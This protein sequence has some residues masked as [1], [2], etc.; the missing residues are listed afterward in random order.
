[1]GTFVLPHLTSCLSVGSWPPK[2]PRS[3]FEAHW[4]LL[5][6]RCLRYIRIASSDGLYPLTCTHA[7][8]IAAR[9]ASTS[10]IGSS[11]SSSTSGSSTCVVDRSAS[12][13]TSG[14]ST[15]LAASSASSSTIAIDSS[16]SSSQHGCYIIDSSE[17]SST[18]GKITASTRAHSASRWSLVLVHAVECR[19]AVRG[20][21]VIDSSASSEQ[22]HGRCR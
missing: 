18:S 4:P 6:A 15:A 8:Q 5:E 13:S 14:S 2:L 16:A 12:S 3:A 21:S 19:A 1:M 22:Q 11:A 10:A 17:S 9:A 7:R 20:T